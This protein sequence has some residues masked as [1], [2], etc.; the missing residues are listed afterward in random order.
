MGNTLSWIEILKFCNEQKVVPTKLIKQSKLSSVTTY[1]HINFLG[2]I[3]VLK[4]ENRKII[5][6][7]KGRIAQELI[8]KLNDL[9]DNV[10]LK[11]NN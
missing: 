1:R 8:Y 5:L 10:L 11:C 2:E 3:G 6:T 7:E 4:K 9:C